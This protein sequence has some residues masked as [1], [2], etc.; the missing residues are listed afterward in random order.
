MGCIFFR[1][2]AFSEFVQDLSG[3]ALW[4]EK[5][6]IDTKTPGSWQYFSLHCGRYCYKHL[7]GLEAFKGSL[8]FPSSNVCL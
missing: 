8:P 3:S 2:L 5:T 1:T 4:Q 7:E 6:I